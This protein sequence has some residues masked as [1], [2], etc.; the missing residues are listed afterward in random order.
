MCLLI[1]SLNKESKRTLASN[2][3]PIFLAQ[4]I[5]S[6][7][8]LFRFYLID[9][10]EIFMNLF[11][12]F[13][14]SSHCSFCLCRRESLREIDYFPLDRIFLS[15]SVWLFALVSASSCERMLFDCLKTLKNVPLMEQR[16]GQ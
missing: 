6:E 5:K 12:S 8:Y 14:F 7:F 9:S 13:R 15:L 2:S 4:L 16:N 11:C 1:Q 3:Q 10:E